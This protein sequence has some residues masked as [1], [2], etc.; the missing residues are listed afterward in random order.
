MSLTDEV[1]L[2][3]G[4]IMGIC[5]VLIAMGL[6]RVCAVLAT[7]HFKH[8]EKRREINKTIKQLEDHANR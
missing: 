4:M 3:L 8:R 1:I 7:I 5:C 2:L 6:W